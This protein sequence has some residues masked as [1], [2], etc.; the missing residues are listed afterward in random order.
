MSTQQAP[1]YELCSYSLDSIEQVRAIAA[2]PC[3]VCKCMKDA[4]KGVLESGCAHKA[5]QEYIDDQWLC[6]HHAIR[7]TVVVKLNTQFAVMS[8]CDESYYPTLCILQHMC[9]DISTETVCFL[10]WSCTQ[11][12]WHTEICIFETKTPI[13]IGLWCDGKYLKWNEGTYA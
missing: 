6:D 2:R 13:G 4:Q 9:Q 5:D 11:N 7:S 10:L 1:Q 3:S 12:L 8:Y